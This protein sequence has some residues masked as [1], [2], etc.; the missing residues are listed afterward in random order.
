LLLIPDHNIRDN[1]FSQQENTERIHILKK[2]KNKIKEINLDIEQGNETLDKECYNTD[3]Q[4]LK[5]L[6]DKVWS[7]S[8]LS[9]Q[10][11]KKIS[12][13]KEQIKNKSKRLNQILTF[14]P[15][16]NIKVYFN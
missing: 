9:E 1:S 3:C 2:L 11:E 15:K 10:D 14:E 12:L 8:D 13:T 6:L 7:N 16:R 4:K 5:S